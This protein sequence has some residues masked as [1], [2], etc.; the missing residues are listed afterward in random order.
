MPTKSSCSIA[1]L[2]A[3]ARPF[4]DATSMFSS[5]VRLAKILV[6]WKVRPIPRAKTL[7]GETLVIVLSA[8]YTCPASAL[9]Y[10][11]MTL[12]SVVLPDPFGPIRPATVP[13]ST[14]TVQVS[15]ACTPP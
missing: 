14:S 6:S 9:A 5:T 3:A 13:S 2:R 10:P 15:S 7:S 1:R 12:N 8:R 11:V 4:G